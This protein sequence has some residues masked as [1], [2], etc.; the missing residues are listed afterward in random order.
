LYLALAPLLQHIAVRKFDV[1]EDE[2]EALVHDV[3]LTYLRLS[4]GVLD[5]RKWFIGAISHACRAYWRKAAKV[6]ELDEVPPGYFTVVPSVGTKVLARELMEALAPRDRRILWLRFAEGYTVMEVARAI[7]VSHSRAEKLLRRSIE[8]ARRV[9]AAAAPDAEESDE[10]HRRQGCGTAPG[11]DTF[12]TRGGVSE[13]GGASHRSATRGT[14]WWVRHRTPESGRTRPRMTCNK[15][16]NLA[17][18]A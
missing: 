7:G 14:G 11:T 4:P 8:R 10:T 6:A 9:A 15:C 18:S 2:A 17:E 13:G 5:Q 3:V 16:K 12:A 1:P